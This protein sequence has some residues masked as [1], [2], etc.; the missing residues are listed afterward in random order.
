MSCFSLWRSWIRQLTMS[1]Y[2]LLLIVAI[3]F[4]A[5]DLDANKADTHVWG[6]FIGGLFVLFSIPITLWGILQHAIYYTKPFLQRR[7]IRILWMVP[8]YA[9]DAWLALRFPYA[10]IYLDTIRECYEAYVIYNFMT[11]L[12]AY[13][14]DRYPF[15]ERDL[16]LQ[17]D[18]KLSFPLCYLTPWDGKKFLNRCKHGVLQYTLVRPVTT[19]LALIC[20]L[21]GVYHEGSF[22]GDGAWLY[23]T[24]INSISQ[25][26]SLYCLV[27]FYQ[28][29]KEE[30]KP[31]QPFKKFMCIK[32]VIFLS[33]WQSV[34]LEFLVAIG[35]IK[36][37]TNWVVYDT[38]KIAAGIQDFAICI[39]MFVAS[40]AHYFAF[41]HHP[42][43]DPSQQRN[44][45]SFF[46]SL[47]H[48]LNIDDVT[49]DVKDHVRVV[50]KAAS[51]TLGMSLPRPGYGANS[52]HIPLVRYSQQGNDE[53][54]SVSF[55]YRPRNGSEDSDSLINYTEFSESIR[56]SNEHLPAP[57][58]DQI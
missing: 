28:N 2:V 58:R 43:I 7:E 10:A 50:G 35:A 34:L 4:I 57:R 11:Y 17:P 1:I 52:E 56:R 39:E 31:M 32:F 20:E 51:R 8:I 22:K 23:L 30:L 24:I 29:M 36:Q 14:W 45:S 49:H 38:A 44:A 12:L 53:S 6:W 5:I 13:L 47:R 19:S 26:W 9:T 27:I 37:D 3:V 42:Y 15:L 33:F 40:I 46:Q 41:S 16:L 54:L 55:E 25:S 18:V 21:S 48:M